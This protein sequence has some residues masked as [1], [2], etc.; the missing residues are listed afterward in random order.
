MTVHGCLSRLSLCGPVQGE[1]RLSPDD[2]WERLQ[3]SRDPTDGVSGYRKWMYGFDWI[4]MNWIMSLK[5]P[6]MTFIVIWHYIN[7]TRLKM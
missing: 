4:T 3:P 6:E 1:P 2:R 5:R 7:K